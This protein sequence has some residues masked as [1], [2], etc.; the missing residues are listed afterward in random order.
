MVTLII[1]VLFGLFMVIIGV[2]KSR[3]FSA[4]PTSQRIVEGE[5]K[6]FVFP[7]NDII[8]NQLTTMDIGTLDITDRHFGSPIDKHD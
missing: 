5:E 3:R 2:R 6:S 7:R 8:D 1:I 4:R